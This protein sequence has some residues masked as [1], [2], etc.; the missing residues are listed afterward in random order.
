VPVCRGKRLT[1]IASRPAA[2]LLAEARM[3]MLKAVPVSLIFTVLLGFSALSGFCLDGNS[4]SGKPAKTSSS[5]RLLQQVGVIELPGPK[6]KRFDYLTIDQLD[7]YLLSNHL[8]AGLLYIID[9]RTSKVAKAIPGVPGAEGVV[10]VPELHRAYTADWYENS[11]AIIDL[12]AMK[13]IRKLETREKPDGIAYASPF[14]KLYVS[15]E[16]GRAV[17]VV[18]ANTNRIV[19]TLE[20]D[21][22]TGMPQYDPVARLLYVN[23][24][25]QNVL[26]AIDPARDKV[27]A[28]WPVKGCV[29]NHG[30]ALD[31]EH[32]R[33]F[34]S[35][36]GNDTLTVFALDTHAAIAH[37]PMA[38][39]ADVV[40]F[41]PGLR[42]VYVGCFSGAISIFSEDDPGH[43]RKLGDFPAQKRVHSL[44]VDTETHR[45]Y[46]PQEQV[47]GKPA[48]RI[49]IYQP[50]AAQ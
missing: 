4:K 38:N 17:A 37:L 14:H 32:R 39:G 8:A 30:M 48:A 7:H 13:V 47:E 9:L 34:L 35:C 18:D 46:V 10:A 24:Q 50:P 2:A 3:R 5:S 44:A 19:N 27:V 26:A 41:D 20:F 16:R 49:V 1:R 21:S 40:A 25:D 29:S 11:I 42:R 31:P 15:D 6:G 33:A 45:L 43:Y 12:Q 36:E 23:L 22:E 28:R